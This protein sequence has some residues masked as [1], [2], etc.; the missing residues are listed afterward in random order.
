MT[1]VLKLD[2]VSD[3]KKRCLMSQS[4]QCLGSIVPLEMFKLILD[5]DTSDLCQENKFFLQ[6]FLAGMN[7]LQV[8]LE[9]SKA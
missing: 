3:L 4:T 7:E 8:T 6:I 1:N 9:C 5:T 2:E